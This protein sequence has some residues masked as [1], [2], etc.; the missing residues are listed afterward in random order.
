MAQVT[1]K[2]AAFM[3]GVIAATVKSGYIRAD[4]HFIL[5]LWDDSE[6]DAGL[7]SADPSTLTAANNYTDQAEADAIAAAGSYT[8]G[9]IAAVASSSASYADQSEADAIAAAGSYTDSAVAAHAAAIDLRTLGQELD[10]STDLDNV[11]TPGIYWQSDTA[12]ASLLLNYPVALA[13]LL[14]VHSNGSNMVWQ[15][16]RSY[17][18][19]ATHMWLRGYHDGT[20]YD[21]RDLDLNKYT[22]DGVATVPFDGTAHTNFVYVPF[23]LPYASTPIMQITS[24]N[25]G[26]NVSYSGL[27]TNGLNIYA[28]R[29]DLS[30]QGS[31]VNVHWTA[32]GPLL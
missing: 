21:W 18:G 20:W 2:T 29:L 15:R 13:G 22:Q 11:T 24:G 14:E 26:L 3:D 25:V 1:G 28:R 7:I 27:T 6:V 17:A 16:Y 9:Q 8:D 5:T 23:P 12:D 30:N 4:N 10:G 19:A 32:R 31:D